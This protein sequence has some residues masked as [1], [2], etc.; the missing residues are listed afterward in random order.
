MDSHEDPKEIDQLAQKIFH[1][2]C[3]TKIKEKKF[4]QRMGSD[5]EK[6]CEHLNSDTAHDLLRDD[7]FFDLT[8]KLTKRYSKTNPSKD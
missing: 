3:K 7:E 4:L 5:Y 6:M 1:Y 8:M 2:L